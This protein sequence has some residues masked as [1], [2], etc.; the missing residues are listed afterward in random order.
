VLKAVKRNVN[1]LKLATEELKNDKE[2]ILKAVNQDGNS[3][4]YA[5]EKL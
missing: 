1:S 5:S 3:L 4:E 2:F